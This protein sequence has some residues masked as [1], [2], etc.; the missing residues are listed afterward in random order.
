M[1]GTN[2]L[3]QFLYQYGHV[4]VQKLNPKSKKKSGKKKSLTSSH[5]QIVKSATISTRVTVPQVPHNVGL[6][7]VSVGF[8]LTVGRQ[9]G[10][11]KF[12]PFFS[13]EF[14]LFPENILLS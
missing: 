1:T 13:L 2:P 6:K 9:I 14:D 4:L 5:H 3:F 11:S 8:D 12:V 7:V 10:Y